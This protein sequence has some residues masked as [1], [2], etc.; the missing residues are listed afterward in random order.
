MESSENNLKTILEKETNRIRSSYTGNDVIFALIEFIRSIDYQAFMLGHNL[1]PGDLALL[2]K[3]KFGW[4]LPFKVFYQD[5][6]LGEVPLFPS[7]KESYEWSDSIIQHAGSIQI[8][9]QLLDYLKADLMQL[10]AQDQNHFIFK[11]LTDYPVEYFEHLSLDY[12]YSLVDQLLEEKGKK[13][14]EE[15]PRVRKKLEEIVNLEFDEFISYKA[16]EEFDLFYKRFGYLYLMTSQTIDE[17]DE[18]DKFGEYLY[19]DYLDIAEYVCMEGIMHRDCCMALAEKTSHK[20]YLR[21]ILTHGFSIDKFVSSLSNYLDW[22]EA[23]TRQVV[24][25]FAI[26]KENYLYHLSYPKASAS[27]YFELGKDI[28]VRSTFGCL[29]RP[30]Y[31]LN[32]ELK[33]RFPTD[34]F[35]AVNNRELR[36]KKQ[37]YSFFEQDRFIKVEENIK[38]KI[39]KDTTDIDAVIYDKEKNVLALF[40][41]KWQDTFYTSMK[42]RFSRISNLVPKS[43]EWIDKLERWLRGNQ[44]KS[45]LNTLRIKHDKIEDIFLFVIARNHMHFSNQKL[46]DRAVWASWYQIIEASAKVKDPRMTN[47]IAE[48]AAKLKFFYPENRR[49]FEDAEMTKEASFKF[50]R[51]KITIKT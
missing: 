43:V 18:E 16:N 38:I 25:C 3:Y 21:N 35:N 45:I 44:T 2:Q 17:F 50:S 5:L 40:Q 24:S 15:L 6:V 7:L 1:R 29:D 37:L 28:W 20:I 51:Y 33:R 10:E 12:Y 47:P 39:D 34:Y 11:N 27:P 4:A 23:K 13:L 9:Y 14:V 30:V 49:Q 41:L 48:F 26:T 31:F 22:E 19:K 8:C 32:R 46:D 42:E 36:F